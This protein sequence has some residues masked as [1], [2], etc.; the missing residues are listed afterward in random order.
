V[1]LIALRIGERWMPAG[2]GGVV[3]ALDATGR[4]VVA[5]AR[6]PLVPVAIAI[7]VILTVVVGL[8]SPGVLR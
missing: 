1:T 8:V 5:G 4:L 2:D 3:S 6:L 7:A